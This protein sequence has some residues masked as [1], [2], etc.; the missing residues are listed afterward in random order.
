M[1]LQFQLTV[2][3]ALLLAELRKALISSIIATG[4][5]TAVTFSAMSTVVD[6]HRTG[7]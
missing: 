3:G 4:F 5:S 6:N 1:H 2:K 7:A